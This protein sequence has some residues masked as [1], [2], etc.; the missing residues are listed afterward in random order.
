MLLKA[1]MCGLRRYTDPNY[2]SHWTAEHEKICV[3]TAREKKR[4]EVVKLWQNE[5]H[6][7]QKPMSRIT[8]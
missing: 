2:V 1:I 7:Y 8:P 3:F 4:R 5:I 6:A